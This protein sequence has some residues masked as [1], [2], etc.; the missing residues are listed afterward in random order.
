VVAHAVRLSR[1]FALSVRAV[2]EPRAERRIPVRSETGRRWVTT[3]GAQDANDRRR[4]AVPA[5]CTW[6]LGERATRIGGRSH[7]LRRAVAEHGSTLDVLL[8]AHR[9]AAAA[10]RC[11]RRLLEAGPAGCP[12]RGAPSGGPPAR[13]T[14]DERG[15]DAAALARRPDLA[16]AE[17]LPVRA[18]TRCND[19]VGQAHQ[20]TRVR[21]RV[22]TWR[23]VAGRRAAERG[24]QVSAEPLHA[25]EPPRER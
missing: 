15:S 13:L 11:F 2:E 25:R 18:A 24:R 9:D 19:R 5:G 7:R 17:P 22:A 21:E 16:G 14:T 12:Q 20:P 8:Q 4:R 6:R 23:A 10:D 3:C 1:R